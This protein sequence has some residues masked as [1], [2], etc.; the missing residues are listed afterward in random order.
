MFV[1]SS[2]QFVAL[3]RWR[4]DGSPEKRRLLDL[5][6]GDGVVTSVMAKLFDEVYVTEVSHPMKVILAE[7]GFRQGCIR[8]ILPFFLL[9]GACSREARLS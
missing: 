1:F 6:A 3:T 9:L 7:R 5:G 8:E 4:E 2:E